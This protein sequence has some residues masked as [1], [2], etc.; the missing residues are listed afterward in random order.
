[1]GYTGLLDIESIYA[2]ESRD[3]FALLV[4]LLAA[5]AL[6]SFLTFC[7]TQ[8]NENIYRHTTARRTAKNLTT[9]LPCI[10]NY[11]M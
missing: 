5:Y 8:V 9:P 4:P 11:D 2:I 6:A 3:A 7:T 10:V 1:M